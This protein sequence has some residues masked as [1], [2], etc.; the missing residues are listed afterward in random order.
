M[1]RECTPAVRAALGF[2]LA[3]LAAAGVGLLLTGDREFFIYLGVM[4]AL[5]VNEATEF[6]TTRVVSD[7]NVGGFE[8]TGWDLVA[9]LVGAAAAVVILVA[10]RRRAG[11]PPRAS[12]AAPA[13]P[14]P[15]QL[16]PMRAAGV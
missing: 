8:N 9:N 6:L 11:S 5:S 15:H 10:G 13:S 3:Y 7:T 2:T 12:R 14:P 4:S 16:V 1:E